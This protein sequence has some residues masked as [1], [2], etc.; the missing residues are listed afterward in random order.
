MWEAVSSLLTEA[1]SLR[2][3]LQAIIE[4]ERNIHGDPDARACAARLAETERKRDKY[5]EMFA[6][7]VMTLDELKEARRPRRTARNGGERT[8]VVDG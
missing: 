4:Q 7:E 3:D 6:A 5:Q 8:C 2:Q 1:E